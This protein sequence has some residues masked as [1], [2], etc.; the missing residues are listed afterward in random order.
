MVA[1]VDSTDFVG[2]ALD[3]TLDIHKTVPAGRVHYCVA[4][5]G[6]VDVAGIVSSRCKSPEVE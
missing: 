1:V 6:V 4:L 2:I 3:H 5:V